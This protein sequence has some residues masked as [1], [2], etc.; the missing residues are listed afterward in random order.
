MGSAQHFLLSAAVLLFSF[1]FE[2][3][4]FFFLSLWMCAVPLAPV[5]AAPSEELELRGSWGAQSCLLIPFCPACMFF[6]KMA[7]ESMPL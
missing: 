1:Q 3:D 4:F 5:T 7:G 6:R 2:L